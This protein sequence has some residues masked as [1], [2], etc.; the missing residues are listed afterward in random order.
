MNNYHPFDEDDDRQDNHAGINRSGE[1]DD[2][3]RSTMTTVATVVNQVRGTDGQSY[4]IPINAANLHGAIDFMKKV[5][6]SEALPYRARRD[7][8]VAVLKMAYD[9]KRLPAYARIH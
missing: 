1:Y 2:D 3:M 8:S 5:L 7:G 9:I 4:H 6:N